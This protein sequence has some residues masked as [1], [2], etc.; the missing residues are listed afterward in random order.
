[1]KKSLGNYRSWPVLPLAWPGIRF[2]GSLA[3][4]VL[5]AV[6]SNRESSGG[7]WGGSLGAIVAIVDGL[8]H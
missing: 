3:V 2:L 1:M 4:L 8:R 5:A 7:D 6:F